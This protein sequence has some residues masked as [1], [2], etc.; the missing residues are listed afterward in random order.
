MIM[1]TLL[2]GSTREMARFFRPRGLL[3]AFDTFDF[4]WGLFGIQIRQK[5]WISK[6]KIWL[7][8]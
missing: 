7:Q 6:H 3:F 4:K 2:N 1:S 8:I 5:L